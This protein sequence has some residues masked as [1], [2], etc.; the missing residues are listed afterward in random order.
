M[1]DGATISA[2]VA[3]AVTVV[4]PGKVRRSSARTPGS[5]LR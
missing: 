2:L 3:G 1:V 5:S 4:D